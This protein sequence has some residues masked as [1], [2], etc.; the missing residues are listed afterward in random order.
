[1]PNVRMTPG[2][3]QALLDAVRK[4]WASVYN[5]EAWEAREAAGIHHQAVVMAVLVQTAVDSEA[6]GVMVTRDPFGATRHAT[7]IAA[8]RGIGIRVV[9]GQRVAEQ[10]LY[11]RWSKAVQVLSRSDEDTELRLD[12]QGGVRE[13]KVA[14]RHVLS[15]ERVRRLSDVGAAIEQRFGGQ[16]QDIEWALRGEQILILQSRPFVS[17]PAP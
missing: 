6:S 2:N 11:S 12:P 8:K 13:V 5:F 17:S 1:M 15:D 14:S 7:F 10:V 3:E 9:E 4:V 16:P